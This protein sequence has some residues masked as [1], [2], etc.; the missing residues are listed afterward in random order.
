MYGGNSI[1]EDKRHF[2]NLRTLPARLDA[3]EVGWLL[4]FT[5]E[6]VS[7]LTC[8]G[9]LDSLGKPAANSSKYYSSDQIKQRVSDWGWLNKASR[10]I[11][12][13]WRDKNHK[14][15]TKTQSKL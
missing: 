10:T 15:K 9:L 1:S 5:L 4:G 14:Q 12:E 13:R 2:L 11:H 8:A 3:R 7:V 6:E